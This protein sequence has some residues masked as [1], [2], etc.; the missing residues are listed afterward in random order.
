MV[1]L[2]RLHREDLARAFGEALHGG[3]RSV[4]GGDTADPVQARGLA[5][6]FAVA[7]PER[8]SGGVDHEADL[9]V[10]DQVDGGD[11]RFA[12]VA[13]LLHLGDNLVDR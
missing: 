9:A 4:D 3:Q 2:Q 10:S 11:P 7:A 12:V 5:D 13:D 1:L 6:L 8:P